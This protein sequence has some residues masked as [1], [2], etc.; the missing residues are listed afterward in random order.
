MTDLENVAEF[1][2]RYEAEIAQGLL[3]DQGIHSIVSSDDCSGLLMGFS[4][5]GKG[6]IKLRVCNEDVEQALEILAVLEPDES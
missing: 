6:C 5:Y 1:E 2:S 4:L 3:N